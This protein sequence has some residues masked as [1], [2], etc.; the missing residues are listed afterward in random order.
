M[1]LVEILLPVY[2]NSGQRF[3]SSH[4]QRVKK[5]LV[6]HF[7]GLTAYGRTPADGV[8]RKGGT[9]KREQVLVY[10]IMTRTWKKAWWRR[11]RRQL[12]KKF[13]Q[14]RIIIRARGIVLA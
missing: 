11:Y 8:W 4:Y 5:E 10:E 6:A 3:P 9:V 14:D 7:Q 1:Y 2:D 12:E 13:K